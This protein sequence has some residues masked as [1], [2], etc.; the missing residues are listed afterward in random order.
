MMGQIGYCTNVHG[1]VS[2]NE[3]KNNL[4]R[5]AVP[6]REQLDHSS[7]LPVGLWLS[8]TAT[9][10]LETLSE[11]QAFSEW[12]SSRQLKPYTLNGF[13]FGDFHQEVVKHD[14]YLPTWADAA[15]LQYTKRLADILAT[16][17]AEDEEQ[18]TISTLP[19]AWPSSSI[20]DSFFKKC[21]AQLVELAL[22]LAEIK[23][24]RGKS[25]RVCIEPE[26]GCVLDTAVDIAEFFETYLFSKDESAVVRE[27]LG[28][29][30][31]VCHSAVMFEPQEFAVQRYLDAGISIGKVQVSSAVEADFDSVGEQVKTELIESL[32]A[33]AEPRYL[34]QTSIQKEGG[35]RFYEDLSLALEAEG[36][37]ATGT[38]R[39]HFHVPVFQSQLGPLGTT[40]ADIVSLRNALEQQGVT[41][42]WE[43]ETY[44]WNVLP[45]ELQN[46]PL[47]NCIA[48]EIKWFAECR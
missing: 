33:F 23:S 25:I 14:V 26:P 34:H 6:V 17:I 36:S 16:L 10:Q 3:V 27:H 31:D 37:T 4:E 48:R 1:G 45:E 39:V 47:E 9:E 44:A 41:P 40:Q 5:F 19:L 12:L 20:E 43:I 46:E 28:V 15:R 38:W 30:H 7:L 2:L 35:T 24:M 22:Y 29:C 42:Q 18:A 32:A 21:A 8:K 11:Q 13:P